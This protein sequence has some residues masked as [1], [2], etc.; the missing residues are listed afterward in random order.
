MVT[1]FVFVVRI[2]VFVVA[3]L[4]FVV[5]I[6]VSEGTIATAYRENT[7]HY[8]IRILHENRIRMICR[9]IYLNC[10]SKKKDA[11]RNHFPLTRFH[12][13]VIPRCRNMTTTLMN[14]SGIK[15]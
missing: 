11:G 5:A 9:N 8:H 15:F 2:F 3:I 1:I 6:F 14:F 12:T 4:L 7:I 13:N 10:Y